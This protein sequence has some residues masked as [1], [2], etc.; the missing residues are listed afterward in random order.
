[1]IIHV[2]PSQVFAPERAQVDDIFNLKLLLNADGVPMKYWRF[3]SNPARIVG[4]ESIVDTLKTM[5]DM[6]A[7]TPNAAIAIGNEMFSLNR[8]KIE[9]PWGDQPFAFEIA[10]RNKSE[11][12][13]TESE[14]VE[15][16]AEEDEIEEVEIEEV[17]I[18]SKPEVEDNLVDEDAD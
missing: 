4:T 9:E 10:K 14:D 6:G 8:A 12:I 3:R 11:S 17:N 18:N 1:M 5:D 13:E 2:L 16:D 15:E 7:M